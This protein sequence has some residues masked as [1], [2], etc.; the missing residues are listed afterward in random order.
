MS[1]QKDR[2]QAVSSC[3]TLRSIP[4]PRAFAK[5]YEIPTVDN[6]SRCPDEAINDTLFGSPHSTMAQSSSPQ[7]GRQS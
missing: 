5:P 7:Q 1:V 4:Q 2:T 3:Q 6:H